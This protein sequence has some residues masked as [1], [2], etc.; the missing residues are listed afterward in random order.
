MTQERGIKFEHINE[1]FFLFK[2]EVSSPSSTPRSLWFGFPCNS[3][4]NLFLHSD[5][6]CL[7]NPKNFGS[8]GIRDAKDFWNKNTQ[9]NTQ[10]PRCFSLFN[11]ES[12]RSSTFSV[13]FAG[14]AI[15]C[16]PPFQ[17]IWFR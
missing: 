14:L 17:A 16:L 9:S 3:I 11:K 12:S 4:A 15:T 1:F 13:N 5:N 7:T 2:T 6:G 10:I 8:V